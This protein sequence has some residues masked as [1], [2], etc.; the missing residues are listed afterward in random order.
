MV[1]ADTSPRGY[2]SQLR[3]QQAAATRERIVLA[4]AELFA[5]RGY[6]GTTLPE[7]GRRAGV[8]TETVQSHGP[9]VELLRA[10]VDA[11][12]FGAGPGAAVADT[13]LGRLLADAADPAEA[14]RRSAEVLATVNERSHG[15]WMAFSEASR[16]DEGLTQQLRRLTE[17]IAAQTEVV[18]E[19]WRARGWLR[20][21]RPIAELVRRAG[22]IGSVELW[23]RLVRVEG[24]SPRAYR[25]LIAGLLLDALLA[26]PAGVDDFATAAE[27]QGS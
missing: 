18:L 5:E 12:S 27:S 2:V 22:A 17:E 16:N 13:E 8:S 4:A 15:V 7:I 19:Q 21:D 6:A 10:A 3:Q 26:N 14:A 24:R 20:T 25:E 11:V 1:S 9:K 23:D